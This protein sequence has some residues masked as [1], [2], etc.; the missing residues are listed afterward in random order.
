VEEAVP[1]GKNVVMYD[2]PRRLSGRY[3]LREIIGRG[4]MGTVY[5]ATDLVLERTVAVKVLPA[6]LAEE[7]SRHVA[8]FEREAR[9]AASL[10]HPSVVAIYDSGED[11]AT[12][13]IVMECVAGRS[14]SEV[15]R[16][17]APLAPARAARIAARAA[18]A[19]VAAHAAGIVHRDVKPGNVMIQAD[20][21]VKVLDFGLARS[22]GG[23]A[24][25]QTAAVL[26]TAH[27]MA[28]EQ[29]LGHRADERSDIYSLGCLLYALLTGRPP[30]TGEAPAA[31]LHQHVNSDPRPPSAL[32][33]GVSRELEEIVM[34]M[35]AKSP[36][37]RP[38]TATEV[39][40]RLE[41]LSTA[42]RAAAPLPPTA[43]AAPTARLE[44]AASTRLLGVGPRGRNRRRVAATAA[45]VAAAS[46]I[47][48]LIA[49][50]S[51][52]GSRHAG[53]SHPLTAAAKRTLTPTAGSKPAPL[54]TQTS[55]SAPPAQTAA[56]APVQSAPSPAAS[57]AGA[58]GA[59]SSLLAQDVRSRTIDQR[60]ARLLAGGLADIVN[61]YPDH[62]LEARNTA[63]ALTQRLTTLQEHGH[64]AAAGAGALSSALATLGAAL[65]SSAPQANQGQG[66][67]SEAEAGPPGHDGE[68]GGHGAGHGEAGGD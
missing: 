42:P 57:V 19:L 63:T 32:N 48:A 1:S 62:P 22:L 26:G 15:L 44:R 5:R 54:G 13:F 17:E 58:A 39:R 53:G 20:D 18:D 59:L 64:V 16:D 29:A 33:R 36:G 68:P 43:V 9:A 24:L 56:T 41:A 60:A 14:L 27:Y 50:A 8:R 28:P 66:A 30:F 10:A 21:A 40:D 11:E 34:Q 4:G 37:A 7:D 23:S 65:G 38:R 52:G 55:A 6:A 67:Q 45:L 12:R 47:A 35:L 46:L 2:G 25:T 3:E 61:S 51:G 49:L 31:I